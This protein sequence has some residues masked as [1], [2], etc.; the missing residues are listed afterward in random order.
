MYYFMSPE[1]RAQL[2]PKQGGGT[3]NI[4]SEEFKKFIIPLP[5]L[6]TQCQVVEKLDCQMQALK[7]V[8]FL[9]AEAEKRIEEILVGVWAEKP[10]EATLV[11]DQDAIAQKE[12]A[13]EK[14][15]FLKRKVLATYIINQS[16]NDTHFGDVKFEKLF[17][18][19]EYFVIKRNFEQKYYIQAAGPYDNAFTREYFKQ[20]EQSKWFNRQRIGN[21]YTFSQGEKHDKS[22][23]TYNS[24]SDNE[25]ERVKKLIDCFTKFDYEIPEIIATLY[26]V[27]NNRIIKQEP[28]TDELLKAD[29]LNWDA[30]KIKYKDRLDN[31][32]NWMRTNDFIPDGWGTVIE[33]AEKKIRKK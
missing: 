10:V 25:L 15:S 12:S 31:A 32:L 2:V 27:W 14:N 5:S 20:I 1:G 30:Q 18:L 29:F 16:L 7:S 3:Y 9:K 17:F 23:N 8:R 28:V 26:A 4:S 24:F 13:V 22:L 21:Q 11:V 33:K 6:E 19:S